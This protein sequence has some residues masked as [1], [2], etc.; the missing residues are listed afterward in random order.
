MQ[1]KFKKLSEDAVLPSYARPG[2]GGMDLTATSDGSFVKSSDDDPSV[3]YYIE[4]ETGLAAEIPDGFVGLLFQRSS[5]SKTAL[6]LANAVGVIDSGYRG[7]ICFRF[8]VDSGAVQEADQKNVAEGKFA[9]YGPAKYKK[10]DKIGQ[11]VILPYPTIEPEFTEELS[12]TER[13]SGGFGSTDVK[14]E[15]V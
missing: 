8:K 11:L 6:S 1:V 15:T 4:Y 2:D 10:G 5:V 14:K 13:G 9:K 12:E 3:W 7:P